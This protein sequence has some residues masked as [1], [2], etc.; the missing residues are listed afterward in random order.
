MPNGKYSV[1][2]QHVRDIVCDRIISGEIKPGAQIS[3]KELARDIGCSIV[4]VREALGH[5][6]AW[7]V[8]EK[9]PHVGT[10]ARQLTPREMMAHADFRLVIYTYA[11]G[12]TAIDTD[13]AALADLEAALATYEDNLRAGVGRDW[14]SAPESDWTAYITTAIKDLQKAY[15]AI[16][17]TAGLT[18]VWSAYEQEDLLYILSTR[19]FWSV[20]HRVPMLAYIQESFLDH[21]LSCFIPA[22]QAGDS[23]KAQE[24][25]QQQYRAATRNLMS[26]LA[27]V[28]LEL[29]A[30]GRF[31]GCANIVF[32]FE[33]E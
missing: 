5:L 2:N 19:Q 24:L 17:R 29:P 23:A 22:I 10:F 3:E 13:F 33:P 8:L 18:A 4:P 15:A 1:Q 27:A 21:P 20:L 7:G 11:V 9:V 14:D 26:R 25:H 30:D 6:V 12:R 28:G 31:L 16:V 32:D